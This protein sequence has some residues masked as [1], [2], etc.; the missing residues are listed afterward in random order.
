MELGFF[1]DIAILFNLLFIPFFLWARNLDRKVLVLE[2]ERKNDN[3]A[4]IK[5]DEDI[6]SLFNKMDELKMI[7][8]KKAA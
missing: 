5:L 7:L 1:K 3:E 6:N 2:I 4:K 8:L